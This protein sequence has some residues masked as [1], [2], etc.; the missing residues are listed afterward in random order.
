MGSGEQLSNPDSQA[1]QTAPRRRVSRL[2]KRLAIF[3]GAALVLGVPAT[4][5]GF[6][7]YGSLT[8]PKTAVVPVAK[9]KRGDVTLAVVATAQL[10]GGNPEN[11]T[12]PMAGG[13]EIRI[14]SL[15]GPGEV[16]KA[17]DIVVEF[18]TT[19]QEFRLK[20][21][22][23]DVAEADQQVAKAKAD[24]EAQQEE[25]QYQLM[26]AKFDV[27]QAELEVRKNPL[28]SSITARQNELA[29]AAA[30]DRLAQ[31]EHDLANRSASNE[32]AIAIQE[33]A[34]KKAQAQ[35]ETAR[36]TIE[37]MTVKAKGDGYVS[38]RQN[39]SGNFFMRGMTFPLFRVGDRVNSGMAVA[40]I[41]DL[42]NW[43]LDASIGELDRG[44]IAAGQKVDV[45]VVA[46]PFRAYAAKIKNVGGTMGPPWDRRFQ[47]RMTLENP[48]PELRPGMNARVTITTEVM[49]N[50]LWVPGQAV[51]ESD[52]RAFVYVA[53]GASFS[54]R[55]I[56]LVRR[57]ESQAVITGLNEGQ[58][59]ALASPDQETKKNASGSGALKAIPK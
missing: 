19:E 31:L 46:L 41:P 12:A 36:R 44:R 2:L 37:Q 54:P 50:V 27:R 48:S 9:V 26:K 14:K 21:A 17:G 15:R 22:E 56:K 38:V 20:E 1:V 6:K 28:F 32:A 33:A 30:R 5:Q 16:V 52:G 10:Q 59:V 57:S 42:K 40:E 24:R 53:S 25:N 7:L 43:E 39:T 4:W 45:T 58:S 8:R 18:D 13:G 51:F 34:R 47:C 11:L 49:R 55:D 29:L 35:A 3:L 23:S